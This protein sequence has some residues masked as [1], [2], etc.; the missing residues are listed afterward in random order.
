[1]NNHVSEAT[2]VGHAKAGHSRR[3]AFAAFIGAFIEWYDFYLYGIASAI[4]FP[5]L[6]FSN[7]DG[8]IG[9]M[10]SF[11]AFAAGFIARPLGAL[12]F[13]HF[14]DRHGRKKMLILTVI[15]MGVCTLAMGLL[16][17]YHT[18]GWLAPA[19]LITLRIIQGLGIGGEFGG[20]ALVALE[21][22]PQRKR[23]LM[24]S[25]HQLGTPMGLLVST[26]VFTLVEMMPEASFFSWGWRIPFLIS[27]VFLVIALIAR[28]GLP[29]T[30]AFRRNDTIA[31]KHIPLMSLLRDQPRHLLLALG[32]RMTDAVTFNVINVFGIAYATS[33]LGLSH[34]VMLTG[35][36]L[37]A[38]VQI[39]LTPLIGMV[40]DRIGRRPI[41]LAGIVVC[42][43]GGLAYFPLLST[44]N[45]LVVWPTIIVV[46]AVGTG[47]MFAIQGT[48][49]AE[50]FTTRVRYTGLGMV[51][52]GSAL[53]GG[54]PTPLIAMSLVTL[55]DGSYWGAAGYLFA[56]AC[57]SFFCVLTL[58]ETYQDAL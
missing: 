41:Y 33:S 50:L 25:F 29:E 13:G 1:M 21:N 48:L 15:I 11:G 51:Y 43:I 17:D 39:F 37:S 3:A 40:S 7:A 12:I 32:A 35:F 2:A 55:F 20:G 4:V 22:A 27:G 23:G 46:Q 54:A 28:T 14:G 26:G 36:I 42:G 19:G 18:I 56:M 24:G 9:V 47:L 10:A 53:L 52:Q 38:S 34:T 31:E 49:F 30:E 8:T 5:Q 58:R 57:L 44:G 45:A 16:P 6:F